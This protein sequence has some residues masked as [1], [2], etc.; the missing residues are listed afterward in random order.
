[1]TKQI[2]LKLIEKKFD[3][4]Q[5]ILLRFVKDKENTLQLEEDIK[6]KGWMNALCKRGYLFYVNNAYSITNKGESLLAVIENKECPIEKANTEIAKVVISADFN[7]FSK[8][9]HSSIEQIILKLTNRKNYINP[10]GKL[11]NSSEK[12][13]SERLVG[14][15]KRYGSNIDFEDIKIHVLNYVE[16]TINKD[17][18][19]PIRLVY[20]I[21]NEKNGGVTSEL[22]DDIQNIEIECVKKEKVNTK[23]LF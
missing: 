3:V 17:I 10:S 18:K 5:Y 11:L 16:R 8:D 13:L 2:F 20:Y 19:F 4:H 23:D 9:L 15:F 21:W 1:M 12:E 14:F 22:Y 6:I 7:T